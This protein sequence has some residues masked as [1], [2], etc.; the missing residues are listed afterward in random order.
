MDR[1]F[2]I[3]SVINSVRLIQPFQQQARSRTVM[4]YEHFSWKA[5]CIA[6]SNR[7]DAVL[8]ARRFSRHT[9][10]YQIWQPTVRDRCA[11]RSRKHYNIGCSHALILMSSGNTP[12]VVL[13][14][15]SESSRLTPSRCW[16]SLG[17]PPRTLGARLNNNRPLHRVTTQIGVRTHD[18]QIGR[19]GL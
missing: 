6:T 4:A 18:L 3:R 14:P 2:G 15:H 10:T 16:C 11:M 17:P 7:A 13:R 1:Q 5:D 9:P 12:L 8:L 19:R